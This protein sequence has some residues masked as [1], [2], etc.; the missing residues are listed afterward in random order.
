MRSALTARRRP[1]R[2]WICTDASSARWDLDVMNSP[3]TAASGGAVRMAFRLGAGRPRDARTSGSCRRAANCASGDAAANV[4]SYGTTLRVYDPD[5]R[6]LAMPVDRSGDADFP[7]DDRPRRMATTSCSSATRPDGRQVRWSFS[8][9]SR[10]NSVPL[11]VA[12]SP[13]TAGAS[14]RRQVPSSRPGAGLTVDDIGDTAHTPIRTA[15][16]GPA[17]TAPRFGPHRVRTTLAA[18][19]HA[20]HHHRRRRQREEVRSASHRAST[21]TSRRRR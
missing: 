4:N 19:Q 13:P 5:H 3:T 21:A 8:A 15:P 18:G 9:R 2:R 12:R 11:A 14:W 16:D 7:A 17:T 1:R 6:R 10:A 20:E